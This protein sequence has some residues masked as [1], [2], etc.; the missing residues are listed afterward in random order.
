MALLKRPHLHRAY[1]V[2]LCRNLIMAVFNQRV[3]FGNRQSF[4]FSYKYN[5]PNKFCQ[6]LGLPL[7][8]LLLLSTLQINQDI[9]DISIENLHINREYIFPLPRNAF[10][11]EGT[12]VKNNFFSTR[13]FHFPWS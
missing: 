3:E 6:P 8:V 10:P 11:S 4:P 9:N 7:D 13:K 1:L 5:G 2:T 12:G